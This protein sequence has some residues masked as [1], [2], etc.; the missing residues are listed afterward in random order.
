M[1]GINEAYTTYLIIAIIISL[2]SFRLLSRFSK[3][4]DSTE[5]TSKLLIR[6]DDE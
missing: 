6:E 3:A 2:Y 1:T 5:K 4:I